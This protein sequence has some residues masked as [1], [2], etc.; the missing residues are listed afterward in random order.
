[1]KVYKV[2]IDIEE[3]DTTTEDGVMRDA[4]GAAVATFATYEAAWRFAAALGQIEPPDQ[5]DQV[6]A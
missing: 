2:W 6:T 4:P 1:M 5:S 3:Y